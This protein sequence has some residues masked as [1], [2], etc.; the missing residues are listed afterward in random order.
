MDHRTA[1]GPLTPLHDPELYVGNAAYR[2]IGLDVRKLEF[3]VDDLLVEALEIG[4]STHDQVVFGRYT[5]EL[6]ALDSAAGGRW[7]RT[8][9][10]GRR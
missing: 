6:A 2:Q 7:W 10:T 9:E 4:R 1:Q 3:I 5:T 8:R